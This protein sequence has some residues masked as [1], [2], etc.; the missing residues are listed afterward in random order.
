MAPVLGLAIALVVLG[1]LGAFFIPFG[2]GFVVAAV[3]LILL[4]AYAVGF[5]KRAAEPGP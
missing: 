1:L 5:G 4:I 2:I 3:G